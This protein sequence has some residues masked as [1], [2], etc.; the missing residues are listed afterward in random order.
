M[1][2]GDELASQGVGLSKQQPEHGADEPGDASHE[3]RQQR[4]DQR[5]GS[6]LVLIGAGRHFAVTRGDCR[7]RRRR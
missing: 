2:K 4:K 3:Q 7:Q 6:A 5:A 1:R